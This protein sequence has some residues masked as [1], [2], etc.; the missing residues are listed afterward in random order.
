MTQTNVIINKISNM[1]FSA[2][3]A[4]ATMLSI[5]PVVRADELVIT[6]NGAGSTNEVTNSSQQSSNVTQ[7]NNLDSTTNVTTDA[8]TGGNSTSGNV[9]GV[10]EINTGDVA[11][12]INIE[13]NGNSNSS[14]A[15]CC[16][17]SSGTVAVISGNGA[18]SDNYID[19]TGVNS[20]N[21]Y[22]NNTASITNIISGNVNTGNNSASNNNYGN[23]TII[24]GKISV[25]EKIWNGPFNF[26]DTSSHTNT[27]ST[28]GYEIKISEN[29][30]YSFNTININEENNTNIAVRSG[31]NVLNE[32]L[33]ILSTGHNYADNN[34]GGN[35]KI[36]TGDI[37]F[38]ADI[39]NGPINVNSVK[40][41]CCKDKDPEQQTPT[42]PLPPSTN[43]ESKPSETKSSDGSTGGSVLT[44]TVGD[45]LP[46]T[47]NYNLLLFLIGNVAMLLMGTILRL[48]SGRSPGFLKVAA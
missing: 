6:G 2:L 48:R 13:N 41:T 46:V 30:A 34:T 36:L 31:L 26:N 22:G 15:G 9:G 35:I 25:S 21:I 47:G 3:I 10:N 40:V 32:S 7:T 18:G 5:V 38:L 17:G 4:V 12:N 19:L 39:V 24:T 11:T 45:I 44:A 14:D 28:K 37:N 29:G 33:W 8:S 27:V 1:K 43:T 42:T 20:T 16:Q 23:N